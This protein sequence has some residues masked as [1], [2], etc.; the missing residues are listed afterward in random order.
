MRSLPRWPTL[1]A[2]LAAVSITVLLGLLDVARAAATASA[3]PSP[4]MGWA[5]WNSFASRINEQ[6]IKSQVDALVA[7]GLPGAGY[8]YVNLDEGWWQGQRGEDGNMVVDAS[9]WP[10]GMKA[11]ADYIHSR[12]L[13]AGIY[14]DAGK[15]GCG[16]YFP[17]ASPAAPHTGMEGHELQDAIQFQRWGFD[18]LKVDWCGGDAEKLDPMTTYQRISDAIQSATATTGHAMVLSICEWG[19]G[20]P[21]DWGAGKG[22]MWRTSTDIIYWGNAPSIANMLANFD[23]A[24][25]APGQHTG[26]VNDPDMLMVGMPG[27]SNAQNRLHLSLWAISGAPLLMGSDLTKLTPATIALLGNRSMLAVDQDPRG[28]QGIKVA[29]DTTGLQVY[30]KVLSGTGKRAA[31]LL[32][33]TSA[34]A[35]VSM[36]WADMGLSAGTAS[37]RDVWSGVTLGSSANGYAVH[38]AAGDAALVL[39]SGSEAPSAL[40]EAEAAGNTRTGTATAVACAACSG[41]RRVGHVGKGTA[42]RFN[43]VTAASAGL[44][45]LDIDY[46]NGD[47]RPRSA[48]LQVNGQQPTVVS[49]PPTGSWSKVG[50]VSV[51]I[52]MQQ[53]PN[54]L[55]FGNAHEW[56]PDFDAIKLQEIPGTNGGA[57]ARV[58]P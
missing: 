32:N 33:R 26:F 53:G 49:F 10:N 3:T 4:P 14:S 7:S 43:G 41:G 20:D 39:V 52:A 36:R 30:A 8:V 9:Q 24:Q 28:L 23:G 12:G 27:L 44:K 46:V 51:V 19:K 37:V 48:T 21:W 31:L 58:G 47:A 15:D 56:A 6:T 18:F 17:T 55:T 34:A 1:F 25:H 11:I 5:S 57:L 54:A 40:Y 42:L 16:F 45:T 22:A 38:V 29:E 35:D 13:K 2:Q 50:T